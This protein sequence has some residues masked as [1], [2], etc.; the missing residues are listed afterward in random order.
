MPLRPQ[1]STP[2]HAASNNT[3]K[4]CPNPNQH[5]G[6]HISTIH[7]NLQRCNIIHN[8]SPADRRR[9]RRQI[10]VPNN[11]QNRK[12]LGAATNEQRRRQRR[13][14]RVPRH[15]AAPQGAQRRRYARGG[16]R[17]RQTD[18]QVE[19]QS[20]EHDEQQEEQVLQNQRLGLQDRGVCV[21]RARVRGR[22]QREL[23]YARPC[24][25]YVEEE[26]QD[27][28]AEDGA[29]RKGDTGLAGL[30]C[31]GRAGRRWGAGRPYVEAPVVAPQPVEQQV[32]VD[33][34]AGGVST[35]LLLLLRCA[36]RHAAAV[37]GA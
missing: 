26:E 34:C 16:H 10:I 6:P 5:T 25:V 8:D 33:L 23:L 29:L 9:T 24:Q 12:Q 13:S 27:A 11:Q 28:E 7:K 2:N 4:P 22:G 15:H 35:A 14:M 20:A 32:S 18:R 3:P 19:S 17:A 36:T 31:G 30:V 1:P 37:P 21:R